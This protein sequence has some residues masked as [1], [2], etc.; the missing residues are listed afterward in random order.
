MSSITAATGDRGPE[1]QSTGIRHPSTQSWATLTSVFLGVLALDFAFVVDFILPDV[2]DL[3]FLMQG[4]PVA[5][6]E[7]HLNHV[8]LEFVTKTAILFGAATV[9]SWLIWQ[10]LAHANARGLARGRRSLPPAVG[11][12]AWIIPGLNLILPLLA[13]RSLWRSGDPDAEEPG[14]RQ[15]WT[16]PFLWLWWAAWVTGLVLLAMAYGPVLDGGEPTYAELI[17]RDHFVIAAALV[18]ILAA[19]LAIINIQLTNARLNLREDRVL[20]PGWA[21]W[22]KLEPPP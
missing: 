10:Y 13:M 8:R 21:G 18:G 1:G 14:H 2:H 20:F 16:T 6:S 15:G 17:T 3:P 22:T 4:L 19:V 11:V 5:D 9:V 7:L 12:A